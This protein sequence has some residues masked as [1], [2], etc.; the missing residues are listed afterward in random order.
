MTRQYYP[1]AIMLAVVIAY[2]ICFT[3]IKFGLV[4]APPLLFAALRALIGGMA[5]V[6]TIWFLK[7]PLWPERELWPW[8]LA[9][10]IFAT[11]I[12]YAAM[13]LSPGLAGAGLASILG[14]MQPLF[15]IILA[16][17]FLSE[18]LSRAN[19]LALCL[20]VAGVILV[21]SADIFES[22]DGGLSGSIWAII[23]SASAAIGSFLMKYLGRPS[24]VL[25]VTAWQ[26]IIGSAPLFIL[27][28]IIERP[29]YPLL[30]NLKFIGILLLLALFGTAFGSV[31]WY[32]LIQRR[33]IGSLSLGLFLAPVFGLGIALIFGE[34]L[35]AVEW[36]GAG[37]IVGT[38]LL[39]LIS[40]LKTDPI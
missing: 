2:A 7:L 29:D 13:F 14:N 40:S 17:I 20:A 28:L 3:A 27:S 38:I 8:I 16:V 30:G 36:L 31:A 9:V 21:F 32:S 22:T 10:A 11:T 1:A 5:I 15:I 18:H 6:A 25:L 23:A 35:A 24:V 12:N 19:L 26:L 34:T 4:Y 33:E 37:I 39:A